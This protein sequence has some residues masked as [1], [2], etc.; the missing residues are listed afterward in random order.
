ME[1]YRLTSS[2]L[3]TQDSSLRWSK[4]RRW[5][6]VSGPDT[7]P[8]TSSSDG[9]DAPSQRSQTFTDAS[10]HC[11]FVFSTRYLYTVCML[12]DFM[13]I[14]SIYSDSLH[15][16]KCCCLNILSSSDKL[17]R[18][19]NTIQTMYLNTGIKWLCLKE[20][21]AENISLSRVSKTERL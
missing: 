3:S 20:N 4:S 15:G 17:L 10:K 14:F 5:R 19:F 1:G 13:Y 18:C 9:S 7:T 2:L 11:T 12:R 6:S 8:P 16:T 21:S